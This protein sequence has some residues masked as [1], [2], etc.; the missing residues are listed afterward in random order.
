MTTVALIL[1][2]F[3]TL[4]LIRWS[5]GRV[6]PRRTKLALA[7]SAAVVSVIAALAGFAAWKVLLIALT[8]F[9]S[10]VVWVWLES[11]VRSALPNPRPD[12]ILLLP[13]AWI[14]A[15]LVT[16]FAL[17]GS[18][19]DVGG[20]LADWYTGLHTRLS[21]RVP[22]EQFLTGVAGAFFL[23]CTGNRVVRLVLEAA[24]SL[25]KPE[26]K[27][28]GGRVIG[29]LER[30][31]LGAVIVAGDVAGVAVV[32]GAKGLIRLPEIG[33]AATEDDHVAE[34]FLIGTLSSLLLSGLVAL[35]VL[36]VA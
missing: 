4:D 3:G 15:V 24:G 35:L 13:L 22:V 12:S 16:S 5:V 14:A 26:G 33:A 27:L 30:L 10:G 8:S 6:S 7:V 31:A 2:S 29:V 9:T 36:A 11:A 1:L 21:E 18:L 23:T 20:P 28:K 25:E 34:Y 19:S 17:G 32:I